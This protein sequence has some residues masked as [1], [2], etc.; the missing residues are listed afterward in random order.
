MDTWVATHTFLDQLHK[1]MDTEVAV[2]FGFYL[3]TYQRFFIHYI[4]PPS[5]ASSVLHCPFR[6]PHS[7]LAQTQSTLIYDDTVAIPLP[8]LYS[9][10]PLGAQERHS[11]WKMRGGVPLTL[12]LALTLTLTGTPHYGGGFL[13]HYPGV[14]LPNR[15]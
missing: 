3:L 13:V 11:I 15:N 6:A 8:K 9:S 4:L 5:F 2:V 1:S 7:L 12:T 14:Y 10:V